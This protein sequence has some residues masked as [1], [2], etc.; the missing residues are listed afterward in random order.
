M[1]PVTKNR[2]INVETSKESQE[3]DTLRQNQEK[4]ERGMTEIKDTV[5]RIFTALMGSDLTKE[6][7]LVQKVTLLEANCRTHEQRIDKLERM[8]DRTKWLA[9]GL[10]AAG[11]VLPEVIKRIL[12]IV[13]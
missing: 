5:N 7:G 13:I 12:P 8:V 3:M 6:G 11:S 2:S 1:A 10:A 9:I 4:L